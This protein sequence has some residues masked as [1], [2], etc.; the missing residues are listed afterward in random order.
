MTIYT[1]LMKYNIMTD[2]F[3]CR[4]LKGSE[5]DISRAILD[6]DGLTRIVVT[7]SLDAKLL[8]RYDCVL[9]LKNGSIAEAGS[10]DELMEKKGCFYSLFTVSQ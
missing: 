3:L 9:T 8:K 2:T 1:H 6:L 10:F 5:L 4:F 7:H